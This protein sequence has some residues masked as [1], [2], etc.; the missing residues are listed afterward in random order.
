MSAERD[1]ELSLMFRELDT[2]VALWRLNVGALCPALFDGLHKA[3]VCPSSPPYLSFNHEPSISVI[4]LDNSGLHRPSSFSS[5]V[6]TSASPLAR[7]LFSGEGE[8]KEVSELAALATDRPLLVSA[9]ES[10]YVSFKT[11]MLSAILLSVLLT[12]LKRAF[13]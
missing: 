6:S 13:R 7:C 12:T 1:S 8:D 3:V 5:A 4:C 9:H 2:G 11:V 10:G